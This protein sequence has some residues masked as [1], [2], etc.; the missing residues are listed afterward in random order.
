M[1]KD[2]EN[3]EREKKR[4]LAQNQA[5]LAASERTILAAWKARGADPVYSKGILVSP[6]LIE[7]L[8]TSRRGK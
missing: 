7:M 3:D 6:F 1:G 5:M 2:I 8:Q 4:I